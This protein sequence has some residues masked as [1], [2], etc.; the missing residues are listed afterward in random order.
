[1]NLMWVRLSLALAPMQYGRTRP[2][3]VLLVF[4]A[5]AGLLLVLT[6]R[7]PGV[8]KWKAMTDRIDQLR[9]EAS[10]RKLPR[11]ALRGK[12]VEGNAWDEYN[13]AIDDAGRWTDDQN[14]ALFARFVNGEKGVDRA[15]VEKLVASHAGALEHLRRGAQR[16]DGQYPYQWQRGATME[17]PS[18]LASR[19]LANAAAAQARIWTEQGRTQDAADIL[20]DA[21]VFARDLATNG[22]LLSSLIGYALNSI[23]FEELRHLILSGRLTQKQLSDLAQKLEVVDKDLPGLG[24]IFSNETMLFGTTLQAGIPTN[25]LLTFLKRGELRAALS[26]RATLAEA[27]EIKESYVNRFLK[28]ERM[29]YMAARQEENAIETDAVSSP[30]AFVRLSMYSV[31]KSATAHR[32][33]V[34]HV[35]LL[36]AGAS[37]LATGKMP[38][39]PDPFGTNLLHKQEAGKTRIWSLGTDG[40]NQNGAGNWEG[41]PD[42]VLEI[43]K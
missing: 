40:S 39:I 14:G 33:A 1:M 11:S 2:F 6:M 42:M 4:L 27:F 36:R 22:T 7:R 32:E 34:A 3:I 28:L 29:N 21:S 9:L 43:G 18:L 5:L 41:K 35:R 23:T 25:E 17:L 16:S 15:K 10:S 13:L 19:R 37:F 8:D 38:T 26:S 30:N 31:S 20:L 24:T 12:L